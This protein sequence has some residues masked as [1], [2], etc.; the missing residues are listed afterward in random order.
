MDPMFTTKNIVRLSD[1]DAA[2]IFFYPQLFKWAQAA[3][4][5]FM[6]SKGL[7]I[8]Y[9]LGDAP[10]FFP[11]VHAE[12]DYLSPLKLGDE[13]VAKLRIESIGETSFTLIYTFSKG[14]IL[15][16]RAKIVHVAV[17]KATFKKRP[18]PNELSK[19]YNFA[20]P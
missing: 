11:I 5:D 9:I 1:T 12:S 13:V 18:I 17:D 19:L 6:A 8:S 20:A 15:A 3:L 16:A 14:D 4:E 2:G 7:P 10:Y